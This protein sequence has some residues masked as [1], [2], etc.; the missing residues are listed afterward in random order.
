MTGDGSLGVEGELFDG[1]IVR[2]GT[3]T[4]PPPL[5]AQLHDGGR[6]V[7]PR[8]APGYQTLTVVRRTGANLKEELYGGCVFVPL[9]G[10]YGWAS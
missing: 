3:A 1:I 8:G 10:P 4:V 6:L 9:Q 7:M 5:V 2:A